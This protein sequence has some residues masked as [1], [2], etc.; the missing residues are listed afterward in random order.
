[1]PTSPRVMSQSKD[2][3]EKAREK[4]DRKE[5]QDSRDEWRRYQAQRCKQRDMEELTSGNMDA[6]AINI[7]I[8]KVEKMRKKALNE[9]AEA[10]ETVDFCDLHLGTLRIALANLE[11]KP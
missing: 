1:V 10:E 11:K 4:A 2:E 5:R 3:W 7:K 6:E 8:K 9:L